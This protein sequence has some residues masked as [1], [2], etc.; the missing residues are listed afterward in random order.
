MQTTAF[1]HSRPLALITGAS[2]RIGIGAAIALELAR[3]GWDVAT[4]YWQ[5]YDASMPWGANREDIDW[6]QNGCSELGAKALAVEADLSQI[7]TPAALF[8][9]VEQSL[10]PVTALILNHCQSVDS[11]IMSTS[12]ESFDLHF[13]INTR[14]NW[15]LIREFGKRFRVPAANTANAGSGRIIAI[16]SDHTAWNL[17]YGA[18]KGAMDRIVLAAARELAHSGITANV[19]NPGATDTGWMTEEQISQFSRQNPQGRVSLPQDTAN[20]ANFLCSSAGGRINGQ[21]LYSN[22]GV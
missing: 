9:K 4:T 15:L 3:N 1:T 11:D 21:L 20:L 13:A 2:R 12:I 18:S 7:E 6:L 8:D 16:T 14:A 19:I 5:P 17:P 22:G 10:G